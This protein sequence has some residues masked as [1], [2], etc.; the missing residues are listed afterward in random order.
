M[1]LRASFVQAICLFAVVNAQSSSIPHNEVQPFV[2]PVPVTDSEKAAVKFKPQLKISDGCH[3][4]PAVQA[5][6]SVSAG[7]K[8]TFI[9]QSGDCGGSPLGSQIYARSSW[10]SDVWA[11][12]YAWY[13][14]KGREATGGV[15]LGHRHN[16]E[17]VVVWIDNPALDNSTIL[18]VSMSAYLGYSKR[19]P[20][21]AKYVDGT[22]VKVD[23]YYNLVVGNTALRLTEDAGETQDLI[24]WEQLPDVARSAL[25]STDWD[26]TLWHMGSVEMPLKDGVFTER[27]EKSWPF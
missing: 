16:W 4:Y 5:N 21:K 9:G 23:Y 12:M 14:P 24:S 7:L 3:P 19:H 2:Q 10:Y 1:N 15:G 26:T 13:F 8:W 17:F 25:N 22:S 27:L 18:G 6:G 20:P 11:I